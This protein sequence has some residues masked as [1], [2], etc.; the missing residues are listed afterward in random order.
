MGALTDLWKSER[1][2]LAVVLVV[3]AG[4]L[5]GLGYMATADWTEFA[6][7]IFVTYTAGKTVTGA[8]QIAKGRAP[9][10]TAGNTFPVAGEITVTADE[11][12]KAGA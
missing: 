4:I 2:L 10:S 6:K 12:A 3:T 5:A 9:D 8:I 11:T 1:G 7:W